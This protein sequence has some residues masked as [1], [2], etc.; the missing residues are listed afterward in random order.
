M[1]SPNQLHRLDVWY[2]KIACIINSY[3]N[4]ARKENHETLHKALS[5]FPS[6]VKR[7]ATPQSGHSDNTSIGSSTPS[8]FPT[9]SKLMW[10]KVREP[11]QILNM[12]E[13]IP[14]MFLRNYFWVEHFLL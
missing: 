9:S 10:D 8:S 7:A 2:V 4:I 11:E 6:M 1:R 12:E 13:S 5:S 14:M 3:N